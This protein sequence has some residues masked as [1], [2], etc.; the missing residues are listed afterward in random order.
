MQPDRSQSG[1][2]SLLERDEGT[3]STREKCTV[4]SKPLGN[5][6]EKCHDCGG[7]NYRG[8]TPE[9]GRWWRILLGVA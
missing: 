2:L 4:C 3:E 8:G 7:E 6:I 1:S 9:D 5:T